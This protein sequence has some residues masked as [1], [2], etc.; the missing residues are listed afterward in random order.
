MKKKYEAVEKWVRPKDLLDGKTPNLWGEKGVLPAGVKQGQLGDCWF[1]AA[2]SAIA[3]VGPGLGEVIGP[4]GNYSALN[5]YSKI[6]LI[7]T[8][9]LGRLEMLTVLVMLIP[10]FWKN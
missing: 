5:T 8:M 6:I 9:F 10:K 7:L 1:L 3:N 4:N 2:A